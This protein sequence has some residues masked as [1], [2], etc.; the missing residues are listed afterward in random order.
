[1]PQRPSICLVLAASL[2]LASCTTVE[3]AYNNAPTYLSGEFDD[4]FDASAAQ[5][6]QADAALARFFAWHREYELEHYH[7][8]LDAAAASIEDGIRADEFLLIGQQLRNAW[9]RS[10]ARLCEEFAPVLATLTP[11]QVDHYAQYFD[12]RGE[13]YADFLAMD[14]SERLEY[15]VEH[16]LETLEEWFGDLNDRQRESFAERLAQLPPMY[17]DWITYREAR[18]RALLGVLRNAAQD[19]LTP[20]QLQY[21]LID[22]DSQHARAYQPVRD[23]YWQAYAQMIEDMSGS[24]SSMQIRHAANRVRNYADGVGKLARAD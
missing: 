20:T 1:M 24:F 13:K 6:E 4:A 11:Q 10:L 19:G 15:R 9:H 17:E 21:V 16:R 23:A 14:A 18:Q 2:L 12:D 22:P 8:V 5:S 3:F 7:Q